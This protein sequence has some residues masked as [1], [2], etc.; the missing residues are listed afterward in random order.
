MRRVWMIFRRDL[1]SSI[2]EFLLLYMMAAPIILAIIFKMFIPSANS[3]ALQFA[4]DAETAKD[5][6][7]YK[8]ISQYGSVE[9]YQDFQD[10]EKRVRG[11]D[12][13]AGIIKAQNG[14]YQIVLEGNESHDTKVIPEMILRDYLSKEAL[15][16]TFSIRDLGYTQSPIARV[17]AASL[18]LTTLILAGAVIGFNMIEEKEG[19]TLSAL[20][21]TPMRRWEFILGKSMIG[22]LLP[23]VIVYVILWLLD[24]WY[25]DKAMVFAMTLISS[26]LTVMMGFLISVFSS[27]QISGIANMKILLLPLSAS[28]IGALMLSP[29]QQVFVYWLPTYWSFLGFDGIIRNTMTWGQIG[30]YGLWILGLTFGMFL[31]LRNRIKKSF[32]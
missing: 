12:D 32:I 17:G 1:S 21:V 5:M 23:L 2:R 18:I 30:Y 16:M 13:I 20:S 10:L 26:G 14:S 25:V 19:K 9:V 27:N 22:I 24:M 31:L 8:T 7:I 15:A 4:V 3:A 11:T 6:G 29:S 28:V